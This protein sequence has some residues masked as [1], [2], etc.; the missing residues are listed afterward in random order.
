M[1]YKIQGNKVMHQKGGKWIMKQQTKSHEN[2]LKAMKLLQ[3]IEHNPK[4]KPR[5]K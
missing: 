4:F 2:A 3:A 1:P 5:K